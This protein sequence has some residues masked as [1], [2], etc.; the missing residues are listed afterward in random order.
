MRKVIVGSLLV[1]ALTSCG[2]VLPSAKPEKKA[3]AAA[4]ASAAHDAPPNAGHDAHEKPSAHAAAS[5]AHGA[6]EHGP[7]K[8]GVPF[9]WEAS[10][11][12]PLAKTR[13]F[14]AEVLKDN[15]RNVDRGPDAFR[16]FSDKQSP[17]ATVVTCSDSRVQSDVWDRS[18]ENDDFV[19]RNIGNQVSNAHGSVEY[20]LEHLHTPLLLVL[21]H[22]GCG[23]VKAAM[24]SKEGLSEPIRHELEPLKVHPPK[25]GES[26]NAA[27]TAAVL[28]NVNLQVDF[29]VEHFGAMIREGNLTIV[30]AVYDFRNDLKK[31][32]G[33]LHIVNVN[34]NSDEASVKTF[35]QAIGRTSALS[36]STGVSGPRLE[37]LADRI[38]A[39]EKANGEAMIP[40]AQAPS[41]PDDE[42]IRL[43]DIH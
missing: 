17:R 26:E 21:G 25:A 33:R 37:D 12:Q 9:V 7:V 4:S 43:D 28:E 15:G 11:D 20:G 6:A 35:E 39:V 16:P 14:L 18:A 29:A 2:K 30:G 10:G 3:H 34:G 40:A 38:R 24:G 32:S 19:I 31:G 42:I 8:Y 13:A 5:G 23:A 22:T 1:L 27:W 36:S 41:I